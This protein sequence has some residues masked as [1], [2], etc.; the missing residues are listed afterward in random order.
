MDHARDRGLCTGT[1]VGYVGYD[2]RNCSGGGDA[3]KERRGNVRDSLH[4]HAWQIDALFGA[5]FNS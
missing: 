2:A 4:N 1:D 3:A 5:L